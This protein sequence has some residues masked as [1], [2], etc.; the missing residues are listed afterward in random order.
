[1]GGES[2]DLIKLQ[3]AA[4]VSLSACGQRGFKDQGYVSL[5]QYDAM[6]AVLDAGHAV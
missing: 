4:R 1:L 5:L 6:N 2:P 3:I